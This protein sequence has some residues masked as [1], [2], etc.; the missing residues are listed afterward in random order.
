[1]PDDPE[2]K[3]DPSAPVCPYCA[4][5]PILITARMIR[6]LNGLT[7]CI[8]NCGNLECRRLLTASFAG[9]EQPQIIP[10]KIGKVLLQ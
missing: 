7:L 6:F 9:M 3:P 2:Q 8:A 5:D 10:G 4:A 1:M